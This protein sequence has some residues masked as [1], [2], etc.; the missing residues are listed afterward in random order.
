MNWCNRDYLSSVA[1]QKNP[2]PNERWKA[3]AEQLKRYKT[4]KLEEIKS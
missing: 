4:E 1:L 3:M 2:L